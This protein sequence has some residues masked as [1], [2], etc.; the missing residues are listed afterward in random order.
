PGEKVEPADVVDDRGQH[1]GADEG[2]ERLQGGAADEDD[3]GDATAHEQGTPGGIVR[4][5]TGGTSGHGRRLVKRNGATRTTSTM[6]E[7][8]REFFGKNPAVAAA[9]R[10]TSP[11]QRPQGPGERGESRAAAAGGCGRRGR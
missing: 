1:G 10:V 3:D 8:K 2:F 4:I 9:P 5:G 7:V 11:A 6:V